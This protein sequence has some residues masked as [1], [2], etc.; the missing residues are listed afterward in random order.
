MA[1]SR[2][3]PVHFHD[4][5]VVIYEVSKGLLVRQVDLK[6][7]RQAALSPDRKVVVV[8]T[9]HG[10]YSD[11]QWHGIEVETGRTLYTTPSDDVR[12]KFV[13]PTVLQFRPD[14]AALHVALR[15]GD[16][17]RFDS[18]TGH[19]QQRFLADWRTPEQRRA[20]R[21]A[22]PDMWESA[23]SADGRTLVS[24]S[25]DSIY[26]W[27]VETGKLR[28]TI[29]HPHRHGCR[30]ALAPDGKTLTT[31]DQEYVGDFGDDTIRLFDLDTGEQVLTLEPAD[32]R[33]HVLSFSPDSTKLF[34][35]FLRGSAI[36]WDV[37]R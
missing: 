13:E 34:T 35:G 14:S 30:L 18:L 24:S 2:D 12:A 22:I 26:V 15:S 1:G 5:I 11:T 33:A 23:F 16:V 29:R 19:E 21:P 27:D 4:G 37:R 8:A 7:V 25:E 9:S 28:R 20:G 10:S 31:S 36:I 6:A 32:N 3:E 17:I